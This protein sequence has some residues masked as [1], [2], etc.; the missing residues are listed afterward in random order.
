[1]RKLGEQ[2]V[3]EIDGKEHMVKAV[4][5]TNKCSGCVFC[6]SIWCADHNQSERDFD[7]MTMIIKDLG[8]LNEDGLLPCPFCGEPS[9]GIASIRG[10]AFVKISANF[11]CKKC[12]AQI[13]FCADTVEHCLDAWNRRA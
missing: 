2:W 8:I 9:S 5:Q 12:E 3:E 11:I 7:C 13:T 6:T 10:I 1:M 4:K